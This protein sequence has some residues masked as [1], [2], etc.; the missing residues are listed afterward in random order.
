MSFIYDNNK[1]IESLVEAAQKDLN[2]FGQQKRQLD[3]S[4][5]WADNKAA[6]PTYEIAQ[7]LLFNLQRDLGDATAPAAG[8]PIG[9]EGADPNKPQTVP[10]AL[11]K[12]LRTLG[13][14]LQW[15][16]AN[17]I[18]WEGKRF[19]WTPEEVEAKRDQP[20]DPT[21]KAWE[22]TSMRS[23][24]DDR[25]VDRK[26]ETVPAYA[27]KDGL[28]SYLSYLRDSEDAKTNRV[29]AFM[30]ATLIGEAN[31]YLR[32]AGEKTIDTR[33]KPGAKVDIDPETI[34]DV[35]PNPM[36][37]DQWN[38]GVDEHPFQTNRDVAN[39]LR[40]KDLLDQG[41]F[42]AWFRNRNVKVKVPVQPVKGQQPNQQQQMQE[43]VISATASDGDPCLAIHILYKRANYLRSVAVGDD[44]TVP[45]Y[46]KAAALYLQQVTAFGKNY[47]GADGKPCAVIT[48]GTSTTTPTQPGQSSQSGQNQTSKALLNNIVNLLPLRRDMI[49]FMAIENFFKSYEKLLSVDESPRY[50]ALAQAMHN[51]RQAMANA[52]AQTVRSDQQYRMTND[53]N[54]WKRLIQKQEKMTGRQD[55][56]GTF[57]ALT[58][59]LQDVI[60][61]VAYVIQD[62]QVSHKQHLD[63]TQAAQ[64]AAQVGLGP[65]SSSIY[66]ENSYLLS[67]IKRQ[68]QALAQGRR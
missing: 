45:N 27:D 66:G 36:S 17:K 26:P 68:A 5:P 42:Q 58:D 18:T 15:A 57:V 54:H 14:F 52:A 65:G 13:D 31:S 35:I 4:D 3:T 32:V 8:A 49:D 12:D 19:A 51:A 6:V 55:E 25:R 11:P 16:A 56:L 60:E 48:P 9:I 1:L 23:N 21:Q 67:E 43:K 41:R 38:A 39:Q 53:L 64:V 62:I 7:K 40:V 44:A 37:L 34:V 47:N 50:N 29:L 30:L 61:G 46:S 20:D 22:F 33:H 63:A 59:W 10:T 28:I 2:K 24:R